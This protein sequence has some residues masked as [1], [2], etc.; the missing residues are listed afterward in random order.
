MLKVDFNIFPILQTKRLILKE[1]TIAD[2]Q[3]LFDLRSNDSVMQYIDRPRPKS[4][5]DSIDLILK[6]QGMKERGEGITWG[7]YFKH[8]PSQ[9]IGNIGLFRIIH[10]HFRSEIGYLLDPKQQQKGIMY[11]A[12]EAV[13]NYAFNTLKLHSI[14]ANIN[15]ENNASR[16]LLIKAGFHKEAYFK[17]NYYFNGQFIDSEIYSLIHKGR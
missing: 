7:I 5:E 1:I 15:P 10:E 8:Q 16:Q 13:I 11:E 9:K 4:I 12:L 14:E 17:E 3:V 2:A 6:M